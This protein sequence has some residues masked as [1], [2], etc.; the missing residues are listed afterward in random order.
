MKTYTRHLLRNWSNS[1]RRCLTILALVIIVGLPTP[2]FADSQEIRDRVYEEIERV[3][4]F[5]GYELEIDVRKGRVVLLGIVGSESSRQKLEEIARGIAGVK[6]VQNSV[7]VDPRLQV[8]KGD[9]SFTLANRVRE[10]VL[11]ESGATSF[12]LT[13]SAAG[14]EVTLEGRVGNEEQARMIE[15]S[16][17]AVPGVAAVV[18]KLKVGAA[19]QGSFPPDTELSRLVREAL[20]RERDISIEGLEIR[21]HEGVVTLEGTRPDHRERDRILSIVLSVPGVVDVVSRLR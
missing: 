21:A 13:I 20:L 1:L 18:S 16:A 19:P 11:A 4:N 12:D 5:G 6:A 14:P 10:R 2:C 9:S 8:S 3:P 7:R 15:Q 17:A